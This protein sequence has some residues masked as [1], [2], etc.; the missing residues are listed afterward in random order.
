L[1]QLYLAMARIRAFEDAVMRAFQSGEI[2]GTT[3]L[4]NGQ[5]A[6]PVGV[7]DVLGPNDCAAATYR[8]HGVALA[9]GC[10]P[11]ALFAEFLGREG[12]ICGGRGGSM[13]VIDLE[14]R[15]LGCF[16]IVGGSIGAATGAGLAAELTGDG[17]VAASFF[18]DG[19]LNQAYFHECLNFAGV[20][21]LPVVYACENNLYGEWTHMRETTAGGRLAERA[22]AYGI[23]WEIV[24]GN[25]VVAVREAAERAVERARSG[26]GP[27]LIEFLT[28]R[29]YGHSRS[30]PAK[31]RP[32]D[33][34]EEWRAR[35]PL[36]SAAEAIGVERAEELMHEAERE[37]E[38]ALESARAQPPADPARPTQRSMR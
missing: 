8:G 4:C 33:E 29:H 13:N 34:V 14:H 20:R 3:H 16:G 10:D 1:E 2:R 36:P 15:L 7:C 37:I 17:S 28:Y 19:A 30:D 12:G 18:G 32:P 27:T 38:A 21:S 25:D 23:P 26:G 24:D 31:Y 5:E 6:I 11:E 22:E 9:L 35:D